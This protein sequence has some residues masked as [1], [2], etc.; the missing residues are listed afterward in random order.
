MSSYSVKCL[1]WFA[2]TLGLY[3]CALS[4]YLNLCR[5]IRLTRRQRQLENMCVLNV[6]RHRFSLTAR[7]LFIFIYRVSNFN[8]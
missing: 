3:M 5:G 7:K 1:V 6:M 8:C 4:A 2:G